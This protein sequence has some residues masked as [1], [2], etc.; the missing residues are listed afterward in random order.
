MVI[1]TEEPRSI[2]TSTSGR[3]FTLLYI[4]SINPFQAQTS[5]FCVHEETLW[6]KKA[7]ECFPGY[8]VQILLSA[9]MVLSFMCTDIPLPFHLLL[10]QSMSNSAIQAQKYS[11]VSE[12]AAVF[13]MCERLLK[14]YYSEFKGTNKKETT[15]L[16]HLWTISETDVRKLSNLLENISAPFLKKLIWKI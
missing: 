15:V 4:N 8:T 13:I 1:I 10:Y 9:L 3:T 5:C 2:N 16:F 6:Y 7:F 11:P 14:Y 12:T